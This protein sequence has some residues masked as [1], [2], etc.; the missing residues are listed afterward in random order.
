M[1]EA[2]VGGVQPVPQRLMSVRG[3]YIA[4]RPCVV[5]LGPSLASGCVERL[6]VGE[7]ILVHEGWRL[8]TGQLRAR[9]SRGWVTVTTADGLNLLHPDTAGLVRGT[10]PYRVVVDSEL[11]QSCHR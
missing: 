3:L 7:K 6:R 9:C 2:P 5:R 11:R 8:P 1:A 10:T 4:A